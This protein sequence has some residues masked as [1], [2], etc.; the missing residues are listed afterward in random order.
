MG[1]IARTKIQTDDR[2]AIENRRRVALELKV[3]GMSYFGIAIEIRRRFPQ[4]ENYDRKRA[5]DDVKSILDRNLNENEKLGHAARQLELE[6]LDQLWE[7]GQAEALQ[8]N[9]R[10]IGDL[11]KIIHQR[12]QLLDLYP[13]AAQQVEAKVEQEI[14]G[15]I[16]A[17]REK[18][19]AADYQNVIK[20]LA[21]Q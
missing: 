3:T 13:K 18:L 16:A 12:S 2:I 6:R 10:V 1:K 7:I 15:A 14:L 21:K 8:G 5:F 20:I 19:P 4:Y 9:V 17:L 11:L